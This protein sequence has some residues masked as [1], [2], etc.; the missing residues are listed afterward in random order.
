MS[1]TMSTLRHLGTV[2]AQHHTGGMG[3]TAGSQRSPNELKRKYP[4]G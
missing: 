1:D 4:I 3:M 2:R